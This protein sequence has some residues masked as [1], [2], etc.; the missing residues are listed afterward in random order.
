MGAPQDTADS[1]RVS[2]GRG[3]PSGALSGTKRV[4]QKRKTLVNGTSFN[5]TEDEKELA[6]LNQIEISKY[7]LIYTS[8]GKIHEEMELSFWLEQAEIQKDL[9]KML[10][11]IAIVVLPCLTILEFI[12]QLSIN[13][14]WSPPTVRKLSQ[15][16]HHSI[17][18]AVLYL[19]IFIL[20]ILL[21]TK[22]SRFFDSP[23]YLQKQMKLVSRMRWVGVRLGGRLSLD[24]LGEFC[25]L[26][27]LL[28]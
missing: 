17:L 15:L 24:Y 21:C 6:E 27:L 4:N 9:L 3:D 7:R 11:T 26:C 5:V 16:Y 19:R 28:C 12:P 14:A 1:S 20:A 18:Y 23:N 25:R 13:S 10:N 8:H 2:S 22:F